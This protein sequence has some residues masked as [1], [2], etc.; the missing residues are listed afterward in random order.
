[1]SENDASEEYKDLSENMRHYANMRFAQLTLYFAVTAGLVT[2]LFTVNPSLDHRIRFVLK[3]V[4]IV[5]SAAFGVMEER[6]ADYW[7]HF[8][9]RAVEI[10]KLLGYKQYTKRPAAKLFSATNA[11]RVMI[12]GAMLAWFLA[13]I[14]RL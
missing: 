13:L 9:R 8:C 12:W 2:A 4:G 6:A 14:F 10:E 1:M 11:T 3:I 5:L 7:H